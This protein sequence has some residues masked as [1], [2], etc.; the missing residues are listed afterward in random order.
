M[1]EYVYFRATEVF[2]H[3]LGE[4]NEAL[5]PQANLWF[6]DGEP[7][8]PPQSCLCPIDIGRTLKQSGYQYEYD[9]VGY[10]AWKAERQ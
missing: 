5:G 2:A 7:A 1:C 6:E 4:L 9:Y 3:T 10:D 8:P